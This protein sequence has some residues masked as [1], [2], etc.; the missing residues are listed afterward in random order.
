M[1]QLLLPVQRGSRVPLETPSMHK[2]VSFK[3]NQGLLLHSKTF[4]F[5]NYIAFD[6]KSAILKKKRFRNKHYC[7]GMTEFKVTSP[8]K[9]ENVCVCVLGTVSLSEYSF[10]VCCRAGG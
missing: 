5:H 3:N 4:S 9:R 10:S 7:P 2:N 8:L 6:F 1:G